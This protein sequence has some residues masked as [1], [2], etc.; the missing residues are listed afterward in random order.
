M[1]EDNIPKASLEQLAAQL[2]VADGEA[3]FLMLARGLAVGKIALPNFFAP[4]DVLPVH[5]EVQE[6]RNLLGHWVQ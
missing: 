2:G 5:S 6:E 3:R 4:R 1:E